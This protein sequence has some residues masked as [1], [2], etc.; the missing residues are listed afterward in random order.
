MSKRSIESMSDKLNTTASVRYAVSPGAGVLRPATQRPSPNQDERPGDTEPE[1]LVIHG[2]SLPPGEFGGPHIE[3][4]FTNC[5]DCE[6]HPYF[7][8]LESLCVS[9][10][11]LIRR[12]GDLIQ[13]VPFARRAW[14]AGESSFRGRSCCND[15]SIGIELEGT[16][17][18][19]YSDAQYAHLVAVIHA[20]ITAYPRI[21][22]RRI[23]GHCDVAPGR[24]TDPGPAFDWLRLYDGLGSALQLDE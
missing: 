9:T 24:K 20:I 10:H 2:I 23:A 19:P 21:S 17:D 1:L 13:F 18:T 6:A 3:S 12:D 14:H 11:L 7:R 8:E 22:A 15:F 16:D 4:L 5:L